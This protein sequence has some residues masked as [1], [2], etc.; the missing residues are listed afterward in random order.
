[1][2]SKARLVRLNAIPVVSEQSNDLV[3][4]QLVSRVVDGP[5]ISITW[6]DIAGKH[7]PLKTDSST[8][9]YYVL[10]GEFVFHCEELEPMLASAGDVVII[11]KSSWYSF[12]GKGK[13]LVINGP[14]FQEGDD[15]Y[16]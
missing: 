4:R 8:R 7:M 3:M 13:Y 12:E 1:M 2:S 9:V 15:N 6:V 10:E 16:V 11:Y 14:A 5:E